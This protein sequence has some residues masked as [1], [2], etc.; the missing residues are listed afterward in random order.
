MSEIKSGDISAKSEQAVR[1]NSDRE[2]DSVV[3]FGG[4]DYWYHNRGHYDLQMMREIS[5]QLPVLYVNSIGMRIPNPSAEG[6]VFFARV[7]RKLRSLFK[8]IVQVDNNFNVYT[9]LVLPS[10]GSGAL[11]RLSHWFLSVQ[12]RWWASRMGMQRPLLWIACPTAGHTLRHFK[13]NPVIYQ[14]TDRFED[15]EGVDAREIAAID[16]KLK[17][18]SELVLFCSRGLFEDERSQCNKALFIDH[19]VD[20]DRFAAAGDRK[21]DP[22]DVKSISRPRVGFVGGIDV[23]T[24]DPELYEAVTQLLP[25]C[26]FILVGGSSLPPEW[27]RHPNVHHLGRKPFEEVADYMAA[28]DVLIMPWTDNSWIEAC[29]PIKLKEYLAVSRPVV[30]TYFPELD[31]YGDCVIV[32]KRDPQSFADA[33]LAAL[34]SPAGA[35]RRRKRVANQ[36]WSMRAQEVMDAVVVPK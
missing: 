36:T 29:N 26:Q 24:F 23:H 35:S 30:S 16:Q 7:A 3:C 25:E 9:A 33:I 31:Y 28:C 18:L 13:D 19:G 5:E 11:G 34:E 6:S 21:A 1:L 22:E 10:A 4:V 8:G 2:F 27:C 12:V 14:R 20:V 17:T 32:A 15:F